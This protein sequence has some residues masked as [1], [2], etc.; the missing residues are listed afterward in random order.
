MQFF[1]FFILAITSL[2][3]AAQPLGTWKLYFPYKEATGLEDASDMVYVS[4]T[5]SLFSYEKNTGV[6]TFYD[7]KTALSDVGIKCI[8]YNSTT[9]TLA[10]AYNSSNID[11][12]VNGADIYNIPDLKNKVIAGTKNINGICN[13]GTKI[14]FATDVGILAVSQAKREISEVYVIGK[15]GENVSVFSVAVGDNKIFAATEQ[16]I[17]SASINTA[18][19][20]DFNSWK[21]YGMQDSLPEKKFT[22]TAFAANKFYAVCSD[23][24]FG[25]NGNYWNKIFYDTAFQI[26]NVKSYGN[27][28]FV[29]L[30]NTQNGEGKVLK[31]DNTGNQSLISISVSSPIQYFVDNSGI[32]WV[33]D[34][35]NGVFKNGELI[36]PNSPTSVNAFNVDIKNNITWVSGGGA[37]ASW[38]YTYNYSG[39]Y[40]LKNNTWKN[41]NRYSNPALVN[42]PDIVNI[43]VA[44]DGEKAYLVSNREGLAEV[45]LASNT[46]QQFNKNNSPLLGAAG[47][48]VATRVTSVA[49]DKDNNLWLGNA[50]TNFGLIVKK[51][52][53]DWVKLPYFTVNQLIKKII[54]TSNNYK[55]MLMR[56]GSIAVY[57][58]GNVL[59][60]TFDDAF[61][62]LGTGKGYGGLNNGNVNCLVEDK[63]GAV[64]VG[65]DEGIEIFYCAGS[66][67]SQNGCDAQRIVVERDGYNGYLFG[68]EIVRALAVD[69]ANRKWVGTSNGVWLISADGKKELLKFNTDNS[70]LPSNYIT[71][72]AI[73]HKTGEVFFTT[74]QGIASYLGDAVEGGETCDK[75]TVFPNPVQADY[76]GPIAVKGLVND[77]FVKITDASGLVAYQGKAN[78]GQ[79]IW[80]GKNYNGTRVASGVYTV[81]S[82]NEMGKEKCVAKIVLIN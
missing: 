19:L 46:I 50:F 2:S 14:Y 55:W 43:A 4:S 9:Q 33:A 6:I 15:T 53:G 40:I 45:D 69:A 21:N 25:F 73:N 27:N 17:K 68:T 77:A 58:D 32:N 75:A 67:L 61:R 49:L 31:I 3:I 71:D 12:I 74:E 36:N 81:Y 11:L 1:S 23:T 47:D 52:S 59:E 7:K 34:K 26:L 76:D 78:G 62:I 10:V 65:T 38:G 35:Y 30:H 79:M 20:Q 5:Q 16:G 28:L 42:F 66:V 41:L 63:D 37:D 48:P 64:W 13:A 39:M 51:P 82:A 72:I 54:I 60:S 44:N 24:L 8:D 80:N 57:Y 70:P 56:P 18:N 29:M 22:L